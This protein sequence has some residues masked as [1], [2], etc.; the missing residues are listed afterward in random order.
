MD[1]ERQVVPGF[2]DEARHEERLGM[3]I[4]ANIPEG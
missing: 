4:T 2:E 1:S 3:K